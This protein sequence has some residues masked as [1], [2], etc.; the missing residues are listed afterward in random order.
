MAKVD[1][2]EQKKLA[3][4]FAIKGFPTLYFYNKGAQSEYTGGRSEN[5]IVNWILKRVGP[6][7]TEVTCDELKTKVSQNKLTLVYFGDLSGREYTE[8][9]Q[10]VAQNP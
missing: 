10:G 2:T 6:P 4:R 7:S 1:A 9:F 5:D 3:E 8:V